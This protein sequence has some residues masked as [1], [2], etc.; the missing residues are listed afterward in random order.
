MTSSWVLLCYRLPREPS[1]PRI[2]VWRKLKRL[3]VGQLTDGLVTLPSDARTREQLEWIAQEITEY[4]GDASVWIAKPASA[5]HEQRV[6]ARMA[7]ARAEEYRSVAEQA[8]ALDRTDERAVERLRAELRRIQRRDFF[9]PPERA[10]AERALTAP[11][12]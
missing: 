3:G 10:E 4:G 9:P 6:V 11:A 2:T 5:E 8:H 7:Q 1:T 12:A